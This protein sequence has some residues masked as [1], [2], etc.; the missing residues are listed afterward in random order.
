MIGNR[1]YSEGFKQAA[2]EKWLAP[3][4]KGIKAIASELGVPPSTIF[5]WKEKYAID[6]GMKKQSQKKVL[7]K[8]SPSEK[9]E[10]VIKQATLTEAEFGEYLRANGLFSKDVDGFKKEFLIS[11]SN[12]GRPKVDKE[13][14]ELRHDKNKL[15]KNINRKDRALAEMSARIVLLKKSH[16]LWGDPEDEVS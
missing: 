8:W 1:S 10:A 6:G 5:G 4:S 7:N 16:L 12:K 15:E 11:T 14:L 13:I 3:G 2:I 9:L